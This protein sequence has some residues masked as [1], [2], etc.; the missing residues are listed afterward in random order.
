MNLAY[1]LPFEGGYKYTVV[2]D[3]NLLTTKKT[4]VKMKHFYTIFETFG[5]KCFRIFKNLEKNL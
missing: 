3:L 5:N 4:V 2:E 1:R